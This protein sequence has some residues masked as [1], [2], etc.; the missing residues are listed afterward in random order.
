[1]N[2]PTAVNQEQIL[3]LGPECQQQSHG[4]DAGRAG[5][6]ADDARLLQ[7]LFLHFQCI[8]QTGGNDNRCAMLVIV[9][10]RNRQ[11]LLQPFLDLKAGWCSDILKINSTEGR[12]NSDYRLDKFLDRAGLHLDIEHI[13][14]GE[15]LEQDCLALHH[16]F[17]GQWADIAQA[18]HGR[19]IADH[20][21][22]IAL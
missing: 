8:Q 1:M 10:N 19:A 5:T 22:Q 14:I 6:K 16:R 21:N 18:Q 3:L 12:C 15:A 9:K 13:D 4:G 20:R 7:H 11:P 17:A 2:H